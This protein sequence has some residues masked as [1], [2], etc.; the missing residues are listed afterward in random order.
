MRE[1][2]KL[3]ECIRN[4][5]IFCNSY[6]ETGKIPGDCLRATSVWKAFWDDVHN[7]CLIARPMRI[8]GLI[9]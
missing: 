7:E 9:E 2:E 8:I 1:R 4:K 6:N 3:R 5:K